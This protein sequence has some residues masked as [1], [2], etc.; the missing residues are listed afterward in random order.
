M[1]E[2]RIGEPAKRTSQ[3]RSRRKSLNS[4]D[5]IVSVICGWDTH[6]W[7]EY[8]YAHDVLALGERKGEGVTRI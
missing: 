4:I 5:S 3:S 2:A 7:M 6:M 1:D 8:S